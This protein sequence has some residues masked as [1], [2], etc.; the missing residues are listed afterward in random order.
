MNQCSAEIS[1]QNK[2]HGGLTSTPQ[3]HFHSS[4]ASPVLSLRPGRS[5]K[6]YL[7]RGQT[8]REFSEVKFGNDGNR[9]SRSGRICSEW[10]KNSWTS[11]LMCHV[12]L[13]TLMNHS[14]YITHVTAL[15]WLS[16]PSKGERKPKRLLRDCSYIASIHCL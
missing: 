9:P 10:P 1:F 7:G 11:W 3:C 13:F 6:V 4:R 15:K 5:C 12:R 2:N 16:V 14:L 8:G